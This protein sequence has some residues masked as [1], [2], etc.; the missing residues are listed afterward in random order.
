MVLIVDR[1]TA[2][3]ENETSYFP[4][5]DRI[6][7]GAFADK[8]SDKDLYNEF[9]RIANAEG[10]LTDPAELSS[11]NLTLSIHAAAPR[12]EAHYHYYENNLVPIMGKF[13]N[14]SCKVWVQWASK[15][16]C[17]FE[18][19][20]TD[21]I[22][23]HERFPNDRRK[24]QFDR[25]METVEDKP[26]AILYADIQAPEFKA[27]H[28]RLKRYAE[29]GYISYRVRYRPPIEPE[30]RPVILSGY[31]VSL[32][33]K[34]T[35]YMV[36][37]DRDVKADKDEDKAIVGD[38]GST[39]Q[40]PLGR[41]EDTETH[42]IKPLQ[43]KDLAGLGYKAASFV[44]ASED[45][46]GTLQRLVQDFP[47]HSAAIAAGE[48]NSNISDEL[49]NNW[50]MTVGPGKNLLWIN[51]LQMEQSQI[52][53]F[54]LLDHL[55]RE[56][57]YINGFQSLGL[58]PSE[59][60]R[61][62]SHNA[63]A[64]AKENEKVQRFD[65][66]DTIEGGHVIIWLNDLEK[67]SRYKSWTK[68]PMMLLRR[69]YPGQLH[70]IRKNVHHLVI[71]LDFT[72]KEDL[73]FIYHNLREFVD[74]KI[75]LRF[76]LVP[77]TK[78]RNS[79]TQAMV[80]YYLRETYGLQTALKYIGTMIEKDNIFHPEPNR[81]IFDSIVEGRKLRD[82]MKALSLDQ[83]L[84]NESLNERIGKAKEWGNRLGINTPTP[85]IFINGQPIP[86]DDDW[87]TAM[88]GKLQM[89]VSVVQHYVYEHTA[90]EKTDIG[91]LI[92]EGAASRRNTYIFPESED[93]IKLVN[94]A[95]VVE[96]NKE[97]F[98][99]LPRINSDTPDSTSEA[100]IWVVGDFDEQDG[101][102]LLAGAGELQKE[103]AGVNLI[104]INNPQIAPEKPT[105][106][107][108]VYQLQQVG[109]LT[110]ETLRKLLGEVQ[111]A[112]GFAGLPS[113]QD[114]IRG[115][116]EGSWSYPDHIASGQFWKQSQVL[117]KKAGI[118]PG[119]RA[120]II[121]GRVSNPNICI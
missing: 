19:E 91:A 3:E 14:S 4:L 83:V 13:F 111:P 34:K 110:P 84:V 16:T 51:G 80:F 72:S 39:T 79:E 11:F 86:K 28:E 15:Q 44:M 102:D 95:E 82:Y 7:S 65:Y 66:R 36:M 38:E 109:F 57:R 5:L 117:L 37:D 71:P 30:E 54:A 115:L 47:K 42:D 25:A 23:G 24:L 9:L 62:L 94:F 121:N 100:S 103:E 87:M 48:V 31:G 77:L 67:D 76:G 75:A 12:I 112:K 104:L 108:L 118:Q 90:D 52:N 78:S 46:F 43:G 70:P 59:A 35:D 64:A 69:I 18:G 32:V 73:T 113:A 114:M 58:Q 45:S 89:D 33:L 40:Q 119:Q 56:R 116:K 81:K 101:Y 17:E 85:P 98:E 93:D 53:A 27:H 29:A 2:A 97:I 60:I 120:I 26:A 8:T 6:S 20:F 96:S 49:H 99:K 1:E 21:M 68:N 55:R 41:L 74:K 107:T 105:L 88:S 106:S 50:E 92:L 61:L 63:L 22:A 10:F